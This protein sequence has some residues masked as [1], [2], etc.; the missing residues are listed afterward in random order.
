MLIGE[1][2]WAESVLSVR[3]GYDTQGKEQRSAGRQLAKDMLFL[4]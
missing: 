2:D 4:K 1:K 3:L